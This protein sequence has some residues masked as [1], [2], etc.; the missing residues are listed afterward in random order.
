MRTTGKRILSLALA[1][2]LALGTLPQTVFAV[3]ESEGGTITAFEQL[4]DSVANRTVSLGTTFKKLNL[5]ASLTAT[6]EVETSAEQTGSDS[7]S[8]QDSGTPAQDNPVDTNTD[9]QDDSTTGED[10][11]SG[12]NA[13]GSDADEQQNGTPS[14]AQPSD[15]GASLRVQSVTGS[16]ITLGSSG[17]DDTDSTQQTVSVTVL[18]WASEPAYDPQ[19]TGTYVFTPVLDEAWS[20]AEDV[21]LP[22]VT[23]EI[24]TPDAPVTLN[25]AIQGGIPDFTLTGNDISVIGFGGKEW[26][27][28]GDNANGVSTG[29]S[30]HITL[31]LKTGQSPQ[32]ASDGY[33]TTKFDSSGSSN[34]YSNS[35]L[36]NKMDAAYNGLP[37]GEKELVTERTLE[38]G[39]ANV[40][41][42]GYDANKIAGA[43]V[44]G[45]HFWPLSLSEADGLDTSVQAFSTY[46]W[47]RSP[48]DFDYR[49]AVGRNVSS[50]GPVDANGYSVSN[51]FAI[52]P[53][54][55]LDLAS[56]LF[57][58]D[59]EGGKSAPVGGLSV[60]TPPTGAVKFTMT[61]TNT[62]NLNLT[63]ADTSA[64]SK[65]P[66][67]P[68][69]ISYSNAKTGTNKYVS[70]V[71]TDS[72]TDE[73]LY[74]GK[75]A[76]LETDGENGT[77]SFTVPDGL[78]TGDYKIKIFNEECNGDNST[79]FAS[80]SVEIPLTVTSG[81][82]GGEE[83]DGV[84]KT[85][86]YGKNTLIATGSSYNINTTDLATLQSRLS[87]VATV[88]ES[89]G[90][91]TVT[92]TNDVNGMLLFEGP[93]GTTYILDAASHTID[94]SGQNEAVQ[95]T[96]YNQA[97]VLLKGNGT[98]QPGS[99]NTVY[100]GNGKFMIESGTFYAPA[101]GSYIIRATTFF[102]I[103]EG[104]DY[105]TVTTNNGDLLSSHN[106][107]EKSCDYISK[108]AGQLT[109]LQCNGEIPSYSIEA[110]TT[111]NGSYTVQVHGEDVTSAKV[112]DPVTVTFYPNTNYR[113]TSL[114]VRG[115]NTGSSYLNTSGGSGSSR[116]FN[117][118]DGNISITVSFTWYNQI[119]TQ[120]TSENPTVV[121]NNPEGVKSY[122]WYNISVEDLT[123]V[124]GNAGAQEV[125]AAYAFGGTYDTASKKWSVDDNLLLYYYGFGAGDQLIFSQITGDI[126]YCDGVLQG[127]G[128]YVWTNPLSQLYISFRNSGGSFKLTLKKMVKTAVEGQ[129]SDTYTGPEGNVY[130][131]VKFTNGYVLVSDTISYT[132][133]TSYVI[134]FDANGGSVSSTTMPTGND[135]KLSVLPTP[136]RSGSYSFVGWFTAASGGTQISTSTVFPGDDTV[137]AHWTYTGG[138]NSGGNDSGRSSTP[139][140]T[141]PATVQP[142]QPTVGS[143]SGKAAGTNTQ[144][145]F[146]ITD[147]LVKAA[148]EQARTDAK[149]QS[150]SAYGVGVSLSLDTP[151]TA[152][153]TVTLERAALNRLMSEKAK[154]LTITGAPISLTL[155]R[156][157]LAEIQKQSTGNIT[158]TVKPVTV[159]GVRNAYDI[160]ISTVKD[161][162]TVSITSLGA[163]AVTLSIPCTPAK[164]EAAGGFYAVYVDGKGKVNRIA[165]SSYDT[166][167]G[168]VIFSTDHF[169]VYGVGY[170]AP[171]AK[172]TDISSHWAAE[173]IDYVVGRGLLSG[174][175]ETT[176]APDT[177]MT[178]GMLVTA[179]GRLAGVDIKAYNTNS[180]TDVKEDSTFRPY[181]EWAYSK[182]IVQGIGNS[183]FAPDRAITRQ[184]IAVI[185]SNYAKATG[186]TLPVT[187]TATTYAD[188][189]SIGSVYKTAV[190]A[191]QQ[192]GIMMG[193][194]NNKFNPK[195]SATRAEVSATLHRY[196]KLTIDP[197]TAQGW[198]KGDDGQFLYYKDSKALTGTQTIDGVKYYFNDNGTLKTGWVQD[199]SNWHYYSGN[200]LLVGWWDIG[201]NGNNKRYYFDTYGNMIFG[202][203][204]QIDGKWY[205]FYADG[206]LAISTK[207]DDYEVDENGVRKTK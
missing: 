30:D 84:G 153:L 71:L 31:L 18:E 123:I 188:A 131:Q 164:G 137:Y 64:I 83:S 179:L 130:A 116:E 10:S 191:M 101:S 206:S 182:G 104:Y 34:H 14:G 102:P 205:Y 124:D 76:D 33:G 198:A 96:D 158:I 1:M 140:V 176:F 207:I 32:S 145:T 143:V 122:Q 178:R 144:R 51:S 39:S 73:V 138:S 125:S 201:A 43:A 42:A 173:S 16:A 114:V 52:R 126:Q 149:A 66:G 177:A 147:S 203:W 2:L 77:A 148:L 200:I 72:D 187:R 172:F 37:A 132:P 202:K 5:P 8:V 13:T 161:G 85:V 113:Y 58:S 62:D 189:S 61:D 192:A 90:I 142:N 99:N 168:S 53:A 128:S 152:G 50:G 28:I 133:G 19:T 204:L 24:I 75:L 68:V 23:V 55:H 185:F 105:Y 108:N 3:G 29:D 4:E 151:A 81:G 118:P 136:T 44:T 6:V 190:T 94:G 146:T 80:A 154:Q 115:T 193:G 65:A 82:S 7:G 103:A 46:W 186:Y 60:A 67:E 159:K 195:S 155:D 120:P 112:D 156:E 107:K 38:G 25:A 117:M 119:T 174:T 163:G 165:D 100:G 87:S 36:Q 56:V 180:F 57:A 170:T 183:Q 59:A 184:E 21:E 106:R 35:T 11:V 135:G 78:A 110:L 166:N 171:S 150:R 167:S 95:L 162:K 20:L 160:T 45:A 92:L 157:A 9:L 22:V 88:Q 12:N 26:Y 199:G 194:T 109:V 48:G 79:D 169:S 63:V 47:L 54:F 93:Q 97:T 197:V 41:S 86:Y 111:V 74:Y 49:A 98:Y 181:I 134:T 69:T 89:D 17:A 40:G 15:G 121:T 141:I 129:T 91:I 196:I 27:I 139:T 70:A 127:D 175:A